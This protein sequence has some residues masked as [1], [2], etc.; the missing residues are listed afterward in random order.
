MKKVMKLGL[1]SLLGA[2]VGNLIYHLLRA[3]RQAQQVQTGTLPEMEV[4]RAA[5]VP[6]TTLATTLLASRVKQQPGW[7]SFLLAVA[8]TLVAVPA[9]RSS[10]YGH[11]NDFLLR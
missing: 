5:W 4:I 9:T 11:R 6:Q 1:S 10:R 3:Y 7:V 8:L 2:V